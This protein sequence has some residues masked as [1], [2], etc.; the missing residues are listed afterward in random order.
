[1]SL[2]VTEVEAKS[3]P[4][5]ASVGEIAR[6]KKKRRAPRTREGQGRGLVVGRFVCYMYGIEMFGHHE[7]VFADF[8]RGVDVV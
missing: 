5:L 7:Q 3:V 1:M 8:V 4:L 6:K 2:D